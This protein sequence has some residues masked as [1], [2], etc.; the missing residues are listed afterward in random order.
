MNKK[1]IAFVLQQ[2]L[3]TSVVE[4]G[5][6]VE[7]NIFIPVSPLD[8]PSVKVIVSNIPPFVKNE[9]T[10]LALRH[11][12]A[13]VSRISMVPLRCRDDHFK[14]VYSFR[15]QLFMGFE[16]NRRDLDVRFTNKH[17]NYNYQMFATQV[18]TCYA[19]NEH[20]HL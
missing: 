6:S 3:V 13:V 18:L 15:R 1:V 8:S 5:L 20:G 19:C 7:P 17:N 10:E 14:H 4:S 2:S 11:F 12:G 16:Q 9:K